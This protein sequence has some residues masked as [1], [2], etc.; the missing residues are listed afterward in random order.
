MSAKPTRGQWKG[1]AVLGVV[2]VLVA[3]VFLLIPLTERKPVAEDH[4]QL[5]K[6]IET[7]GD[8]MLAERR[9]ER[10]KRNERFEKRGER[11]QEYADSQWHRGATYKERV[12]PT[13]D[14]NNADTVELQMLYGIG[15]AF[16]NRIVKYRNLLGGYVRKE[17]LLEVYGMDS[18]RY[19][20]FVDCL[21]V[22]TS[23]VRRIKIN[24]ASID[25]LRKHP[26]LDYYQAR[27]IVN[28][29]KTGFRYEKAEDLLMV[30]LLDEETVIK[31]QDYIQ[32]N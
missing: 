13:V 26:Y 24:E 10:K 11:R 32:F 12:R 18:V 4:L 29:R 28:L 27:A 7:Y 19:Q 16:A 31:I 3:I 14:I 20:G 8:S 9:V 21:T 6:D 17:Q 30:S 25:E 1:Y 23:A 22:D 2:I 15:P 5:K